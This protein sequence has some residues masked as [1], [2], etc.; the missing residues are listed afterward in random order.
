VFLFVVAVLT[1]TLAFADNPSPRT[2]ARMAWDTDNH[3]GVLF[4][5]RALLDKATGVPHSTDETWLWNGGRWLQRFP[6]TR[7]PARSAHSM[8]FDPNH[9]RVFVFGGRVEAIDKDSEP[10]FLNDLWAWSDEQWTRVD[11]DSAQKP[12]ARHYSGLAYDPVRDRL[13]MFG[14][15]KYGADGVAIDPN[16][17]TWEFDGTQWTNVTGE[18]PKVAKPI[19]AWDPVNH[20]IVMLGVDET[21][22]SGRMY[23]YNGTTHVWTQVTPAALPTCINEGYLS[24]DT[25]K[26]RLVFF[27]GICN[28]NTPAIEEVWVWDGSTWAKLTT[29]PRTRGIG[30]ATAFDPL[31]GEIVAY[32]GSFYGASD[33][34]SAIG[35]MRGNGTWTSGQSFVRPRPR[36]LAAMSTDSARNTL[37]MFGGLD[38][39]SFSYYLDMWGYRAGQ[40]N[41]LTTENG[42]VTC[43]SPLSAFDSD[44]GKLVLTCTGNDI[45]EWDGETWKSFTTLTKAPSIRHFAS[46]VYDA[47]LKKTVLFGGYENNNYRNDTWTWNGTAWTELNIN[48]DKRPPHRGVMS[49]WY[50][51]LQQKTIV[52]GGIGRPNI[53][54]KV[55]RYSDMWAFDGTQW[56]KLNVTT[57]PGP[58]LGAAIAVNPVTGKLLL[59]GG[60]RSEALDEDSI[61]QFFDKDT[62]EWNGT[63]SKWTLLEAN[64][65]TV[66]PDT[67]E[68]ASLGWDPVAGN[69]V[70]YGGYADGFYRSDIWVWDGQDWTPRPEQGGRR[71][72]AR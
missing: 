19:L 57:T 25:V 49:M 5:G 51:P 26:N 52:Y 9:G 28:A 15:N 36:S 71:R 34:T 50:D 27:G 2:H 1:A 65:D 30:Q 54:S 35:V 46:L 59:F 56:T 62:W 61:R 63:D 3:V 47:K 69:L 4:G 70:M 14:G 53:N 11:G 60:L 6:Q 32:G 39:Y 16:Y 64:P 8:T 10:V 43:E 29:S 42:P 33:F 66:G 21:A 23:R 20:D 24:Y 12:S 31:R 48:N 68:N 67:R 22:T 38:E 13:V 18:A 72:A 45:F 41:I 40:W 7:P 37:L 44:R 58:R 55:T 17:E